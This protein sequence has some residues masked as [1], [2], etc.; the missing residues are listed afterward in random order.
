MYENL[1]YFHEKL[2]IPVK[3]PLNERESN[4]IQYILSPSYAETVWDI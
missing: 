4:I 2:N 1:K 3:V